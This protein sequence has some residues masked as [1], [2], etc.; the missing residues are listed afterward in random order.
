MSRE[1]EILGVS[2]KGNLHLINVKCACCDNILQ[3]PYV[4][5]VETYICED[6]LKSIDE[7]HAI[8]EMVE[9]KLSFYRKQL[10][11]SVDAMFEDL[12]RDFSRQIEIER[13]NEDVGRK[14]CCRK[15]ER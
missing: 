12:K 15:E 5:D 11:Q 1:N 2:K 14:G 7:S 3:L 10:Q 4:N 9:L 8:E 6:C 13:R